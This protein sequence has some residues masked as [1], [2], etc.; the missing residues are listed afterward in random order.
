MVRRVLEVYAEANKTFDELRELVR[1][2]DEFDPLRDFAEAPNGTARAARLTAQ[3]EPALKLN[4]GN[5]TIGRTA[6]LIEV[7]AGPGGSVT[8]F[9]P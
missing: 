5:A 1:K 2:E 8:E 6:G 7:K 4:N 3:K 9:H